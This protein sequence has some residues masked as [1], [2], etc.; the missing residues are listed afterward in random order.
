MRVLPHGPVRKAVIMT[1]SLNCLGSDN[2]HC[3]CVE[4][5][6]KRE[7]RVAASDV[8]LPVR[9]CG[10]LGAEPWFLPPFTVPARVPGTA[11]AFALG[12][13][14]HLSPYTSR[15]RGNPPRSSAALVSRGTPG[16]ELSRT[17]LDK[18]AAADGLLFGLVLVAPGAAFPDVST[19]RGSSSPPPYAADVPPLLHPAVP[20][21]SSRG[22]RHNRARDGS[23]AGTQSQ[24]GSRTAHAQSV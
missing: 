23:A 18:T 3:R 15:L 9:M 22:L 12:S 13:A 2:H 10:E 17:G 5:A 24:P 19:V 6:M 1:S 20:A 7:H 14:V 8:L 16:G 21:R 4:P 11:P